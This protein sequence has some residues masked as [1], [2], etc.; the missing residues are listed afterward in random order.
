MHQVDAAWVD[1]QT[2]VGERTFDRHFRVEAG[3]VVAAAAAAVA[4]RFRAEG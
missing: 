2:G 3:E 1:L 4:L